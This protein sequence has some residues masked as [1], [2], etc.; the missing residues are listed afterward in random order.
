ML[1]VL[2]KSDISGN[3][4]SSLKY[5]APIVNP[6]S[7]ALSKVISNYFKNSNNTNTIPISISPKKGDIIF[8]KKT[9]KGLPY[10]HYGIYLGNNQVIH[11]HGDTMDTAIIREDD[12]NIFM[13]G[14]LSN[15][16]YILDLENKCT[17][18]IIFENNTDN[19]SYYNYI[20]DAV[21]YF[22]ENNY[23]TSDFIENIFSSI[24]INSPEETIKRAKS[25]LGENNYNV[26]TNNC[27]HFAIWCKTG[28]SK[29]E[30]VKNIIKFL[31]RI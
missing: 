9:Y 12:M 27:E 8:A 29:S 18:N 6:T 13:I 2:K 7:Y 26:A 3:L 23:N 19:F 4:I 24:I 20:Y 10:K 31:S 5:I 16:Y 15:N 11:Y 22:W 1:E 14:S 25:R 17:K 28:I 21:F 30:Q